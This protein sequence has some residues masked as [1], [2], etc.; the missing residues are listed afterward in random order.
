[1]RFP[2]LSWLRLEDA[3]TKTSA[4]NPVGAVVIAVFLAIGSA[5]GHLQSKTEP[6]V[7]FGLAPIRG[8]LQRSCDATSEDTENNLG[9]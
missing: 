3:C 6:P 9:V 1:M 5:C 8:K 7:R 4:L 2:N